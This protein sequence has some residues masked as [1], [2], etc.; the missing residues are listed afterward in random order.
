M[1]KRRCLAVVCIVSLLM[2]GIANA[3]PAGIVFGILGD[4]AVDVPDGWDAKRVVDKNNMVTMKISP[5]SDF[6]LLLQISAIPMSGETDVLAS[7][8]S[9]TEEIRDQYRK[10]A[11]ENEIPIREIAGEYC[12]GYFISVTDRTVEHPNAENFKYGDSGALAAGRMLVIFTLL[13]NTKDAPERAEA[14]K[15]VRTA[16]HLPPRAPWRTPEGDIV[17]EFPGSPPRL[18]LSLPG[19]DLGPAEFTKNYEGLRI[20]GENP[21]TSMI[22][23]LFLERSREGWTAVNYREYELEKKQKR[24]LMDPESIVQS[25]RDEMAILKYDTPEFQGFSLN[26]RHVHAYLLKDGFWM[27]VHISKANYSEKDDAIF[28]A[29]LD[30]IH[31]ID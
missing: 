27:S 5:G 4:L 24:G 8:R 22:V 6:P 19:Y 30:S 16:V 15:V 21:E 23:S 28:G 13:T 18:Q 11:E 3:E 29:V 9:E 31:F 20:Y 10:N 2:I 17:L 26:Q 25:E 14:L 7:A 12:N 1:N